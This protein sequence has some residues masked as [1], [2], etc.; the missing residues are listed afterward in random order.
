MEKSRTFL[1]NLV[2]M[3]QQHGIARSPIMRPHE[4]FPGRWTPIGPCQLA[5][6]VRFRVLLARRCLCYGPSLAGGDC[7]GRAVATWIIVP[8]HICQRL[9]SSGYLAQ[10]SCSKVPSTQ[11]PTVQWGSRKRP[12]RL[13]LTTNH[14]QNNSPGLSSSIDVNCLFTLLLLLLARWGGP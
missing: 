14:A 7:K 12:R 3:L 6:H 4:K 5:N 2:S 13:P 8:V 11:V 9:A 1:L 10:R